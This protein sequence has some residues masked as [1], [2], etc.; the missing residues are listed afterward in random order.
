M[1]NYVNQ[2]MA[3]SSLRILETLTLTCP[4]HGEYQNRR[5]LRTYPDGSTEE[6]PLSGCPGCREELFRQRI[7]EVFEEKGLDKRMEAIQIPPKLQACMLKNFSTDGDIDRQHVRDKAVA[8]V[9]GEIRGLVLL[10]GTGR[11]KSHLLAAMLKGCVTTGFDALYVAE[12]EIHR[13]IHDT[14][15]QS[16]SH[17][18][19]KAVI[20]RYSS[21]QVLGIDELGRS[22]GTEHEKQTL[23]EIIDKR[24]GRG[25]RTVMAGNIMQEEFDQRFD[26]SFKRKLAAEVIECTWARWEGR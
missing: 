10:G 22:S 20:E 7:G 11:G 9:R 1:S 13:D 12:R 17:E 4:E 26:D 6:L 15:G 19:E 18:K 23:Y 5:I 2:L 3:A 21:V 25:L 14:Y 24:D 16:G 8:F